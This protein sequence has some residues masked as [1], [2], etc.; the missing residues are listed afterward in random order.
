MYQSLHHWSRMKLGT[1]HCWWPPP[2]CYSE[3][4]P[5][6]SGL[7][8]CE[9]WLFCQIFLSSHFLKLQHIIKH[10][11]WDHH[12]LELS[13]HT[14]FPI[15]ESQYKWGIKRLCASFFRT[16]QG[17][18]GFWFPDTVHKPALCS[19][20]RQTPCPHSQNS[21]SI[22]PSQ[23]AKQ[24]A[25]QTLEKLRVT[26]WCVHSLMYRAKLIDSQSISQKNF[27]CALE[28]WQKILTVNHCQI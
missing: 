20:W 27:Q 12:L 23:T 3:L 2:S 8:K 14:C 25:T 5:S 10:K 18:S 1:Q 22:G 24:K 21:L 7:S 19:G 6:G 4:L 16:N 13:N 28:F 17:I 11:P 9:M 15:K 26:I